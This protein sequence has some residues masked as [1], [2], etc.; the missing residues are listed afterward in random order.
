M[1]SEILVRRYRT[2]GAD[3]GRW[4]RFEFRP[5]DIVI[6]SPPRSG[7]TWTQMLCALLVFGGPDFPAPLERVS[8]WLDQQT[9]AHR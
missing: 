3:S 7:T 5:G 6:S 1:S 2:F 9:R 4:D 8:P